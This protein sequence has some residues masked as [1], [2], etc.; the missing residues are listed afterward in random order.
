[1]QLITAMKILRESSMDKVPEATV[2]VTKPTFIAIAIKY[3]RGE[4][5]APTIVAEGKRI[6][7][8]KIR[9]IATENDI[10]IVENKP[11]ARAI[12]DSVEVGDVIPEEHFEAVAQILAYI[13]SLEG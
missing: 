12:I 8:E 7:A 2:V 6:I 5:D 10:P 11:L 3:K 13:Y 1:M 4:Q 9:D